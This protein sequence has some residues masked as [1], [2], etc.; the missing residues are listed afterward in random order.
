VTMDVVALVAELRGALEDEWEV[1][2]SEYCTNMPHKAG[3]R[4]LHP[5]PPV[6]DEATR[7]LGGDP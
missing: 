3:D 6:L 4:C 1:A 2:H 7:Y 5:R